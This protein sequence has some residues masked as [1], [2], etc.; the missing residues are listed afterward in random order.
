VR[1]RESARRAGARAGAGRGWVERGGERGREGGGR[2]RVGAGKR[3][4][5]GG[6]GFSLFL[7]IFQI[8][9]PFLH[10]FLLNKLFCG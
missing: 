1:G 7:F 3:P 2:P 4:S 5:R 9:F 8:L 10:L 6:E